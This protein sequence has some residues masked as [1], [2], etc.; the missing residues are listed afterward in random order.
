MCFSYKRKLEE[1][2][3]K[4]KL[5]HSGKQETGNKGKGTKI[6][7]VWQTGNWKQRER[8]ENCF[9]LANRKLKT[10]NKETWKKVK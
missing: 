1:S 4:G 3:K 5:F 6:V 7:S 9:S 2:L 10:G 8:N